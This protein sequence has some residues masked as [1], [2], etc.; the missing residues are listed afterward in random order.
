MKQKR[1]QDDS[2]QLTGSKVAWLGLQD[3]AAT[4][5]YV[6]SGPSERHGKFL[7]Q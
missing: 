6:K 7:T 3:D 2:A 5:S 4:V 1:S